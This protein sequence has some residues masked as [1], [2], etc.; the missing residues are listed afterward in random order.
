[1]AQIAEMVRRDRITD[2]LCLPSLYTL[3]LTYS[4]GQELSSL[5]TVIVA[6]EACPVDLARLHFGRL[7]QASLYNEYGPTEGTVW[8]SVYRVPLEFRRMVVPIGRPIENMQLF[9]LDAARLP[10]P[11]GVAGELYIAGQGLVVGYFQRPDLTAERFI[12]TDIDGQPL[13]LYRTGDLARFLPDGNLEFLGRVDHQVKI[14]GYRIE[15]E[16]IEVALKQHP[17]VRQAVVLARDLWEAEPGERAAP[18]GVSG[19]EDDPELLLARLLALDPAE[20]E[21]LLADIEA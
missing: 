13:R 9:I 4:Q 7:P 3:L 19:H 1:V 20:A 14:L 17:A 18:D 6:G 12:E 21:R 10:V 11:I 8:C 16:E 5:R 2:L 15:L